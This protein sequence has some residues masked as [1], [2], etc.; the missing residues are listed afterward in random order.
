MI[1]RMA[2]LLL[3]IGVTLSIGCSKMVSVPKEQLKAGTSVELT[4][5]DGT[6]I[7]GDIG[8]I[9]K[10]VVTISR[11]MFV[12]KGTNPPESEFFTL[13]I[14]MDR[15]QAMEVSQTDVTKTVIL[16]IVILAIVAVVVVVVLKTRKQEEV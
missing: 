4:L 5:D 14:G 16:L 15:I 3:L 1:R 10:N 6:I 13:P 7:K 8:K 11:F 2:V 9:E 12:E